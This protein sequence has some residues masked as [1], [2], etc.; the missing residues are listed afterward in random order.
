M[1]EDDGVFARPNIAN[2]DNNNLSF[3][4]HSLIAPS[5]ISV[6]SMASSYMSTKMLGKKR[7]LR[8]H[9]FVEGLSNVIEKQFFPDLKRLKAQAA[10]IEYDEEV[11]NHN[12]IETRHYIR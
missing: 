7:I 9:E 10:G 12:N 5:E 1:S 4:G 11:D 6:S 2:N 3:I 8:E